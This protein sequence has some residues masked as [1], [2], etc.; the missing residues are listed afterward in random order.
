MNEGL[1]DRDLPRV[2]VQFEAGSSEF[3]PGVPARAARVGW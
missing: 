1:A 2:L 3:S